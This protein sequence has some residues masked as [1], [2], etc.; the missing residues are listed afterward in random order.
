[1]AS[2]PGL[3]LYDFSDTGNLQQGIGKGAT[4]LFNQ[5][6]GVSG[7]AMA[8]LTPVLQ[9]LK[10]IVSGNASEIDAEAAPEV[11]GVRNAYQAARD[12]IT[13]FTPRGGGLTSSIAA[14]RTGEASDISKVRSSVRSQAGA[15][16]EGLGAQ[17]LQTGGQEEQAGL[18]QF[19]QLLQAAMKQDE[20]SSSFWGK[21]GGTIGAVAGSILFPPA[22]PALLGGA[23]KGWMT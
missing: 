1:M 2:T 8:S 23:V 13:N 14:N 16:L 21:I 4:G 15:Q 9:R 12:S 22:A 11:S 3:S 17:M 18:G 19:G 5:G 7:E 10:S 20:Q 6:A